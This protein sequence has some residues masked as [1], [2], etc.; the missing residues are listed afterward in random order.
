MIGKIISHFE[1]L[2]KLGEGWMGKVYKARDT[3]LNRLVAL[4][5]FPPHLLQNEDHK[6]RIYR[7]AQAISALDHPNIMTIFDIYEE[8]EHL[9]L[10]RACIEGELFHQR[11]K[12]KPF[13]RRTPV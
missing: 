5:L 8:D 13:K 2:E 10:A 6:K 3:I 11:I 4:K 12:R 7:E 1:I 9:F